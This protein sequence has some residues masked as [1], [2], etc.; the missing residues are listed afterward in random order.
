MLG[1]WSFRIPNFESQ[2]HSDK[3]GATVRRR[4]RAGTEHNWPGISADFSLSVHFGCICE[5]VNCYLVS[6]GRSALS[7]YHAIFMYRP[8]ELARFRFVAYWPSHVSTDCFP[9]VVSTVICAA[10]VLFGLRDASWPGV[11]QNIHRR[12]YIGRFVMFFFWAQPFSHTSRLPFV[13][14][15]RSPMHHTKGRGQI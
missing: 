13:Y 11:V 1:I 7:D 10:C 2:R 9:S 14:R 6:M 12:F 5:S 3:R 4:P 8:V 15:F